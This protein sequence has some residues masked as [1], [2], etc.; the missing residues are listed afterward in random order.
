MNH[1]RPNFIRNLEDIA[2]EAHYLDTPARRYRT[3]RRL[4]KA[5][6]AESIGVNYCYLKKGQLSSRFHSHSL[7]EE[8]FLI[9]DGHAIL[10]WGEQEHQLGPGDAVSVRPGGPAHQMRNDSDEDCIFLAIGTR[11][12]RDEVSYPE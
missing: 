5:T 11:D 4:G 7:E 3:R 1:T 12:A 9:L 6:G 8:F 10:R 2:E